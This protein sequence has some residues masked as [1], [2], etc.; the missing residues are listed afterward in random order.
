MNISNTRTVPLLTLFLLLVSFLLY[1][2]SITLP[3]SFI[4]AW[5][6]SE[7]YAIALQFL[8]NGFDIFHPATFNLQTVDGITRMDLPLNEFIVAILMKLLGTTSPV[9]F[10]LYTICIGILGIIFLYLLT[11]RITGSETKSWLAAAFVFFSPIFSFYQAGF[12]PCVPA[13]SFV[14]IAYYFLYRY[15]TSPQ[16]K[17]FYFCLLFLLLAA[18]IRLPFLIFLLGFFIQQAFLFLRRRNVILFELYSF[19][20]AFTIFI[21]YY[22]YNVHLGRVYGNMFLNKFLPASNFSM[23]KE[24]IGRMYNHW[25]LQYFTLWHYLLLTVALV[26]ALVNYYRRKQVVNKSIW[27]NL[28]I[29]GCGEA[30]YFLLMSSQY[31][32]HDYYFLD[33]FFVPVVLLF[34]LCLN[35]LPEKKNSLFFFSLT[36]V[37]IMFMFSDS[38]KEQK[39]RYTAEPWD[40]VE[41]TRQNYAGAEKF[42][43]SI[44]IP[45]EAKILV[46]EAYSTN[47]PLYMMNRKGYTVYQTNRDNAEYA[48]FHTKWDYVVI[49]DVFLFSDV[50]RYYPIVA[51]VLE[52]VAGNGKITIYKQSKQVN[53]MSV[54]NFLSKNRQEII[55]QNKITFEEEKVDGHFGG[56]NKIAYCSELLSNAAILNSE[57]EF[58]VGFHATPNDFK[59]RS[60]IKIG[61]S[62]TIFQTKPSDIQAVVSVSNNG[63]TVY[64]QSYKIGDYYK[65]GKG[66]QK[67]AFEFMVPQFKN[68]NDMLSI[69][70]W[71][72]SHSFLYYDDMEVV[73]Y[74]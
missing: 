30:L 71:N 3:P 34:V 11:K 27:F 50:L 2:S 46:I 42:L 15:K 65:H 28:L 53:A 35:S 26:A 59:T 60:D 70:L 47:I 68:V 29:V 73:I 24:I 19:T 36:A 44:G 13:I 20:T 55:Y 16:R 38:L 74:K 1:K 62:W 17:Y 12:I 54:S 52:P 4:H 45:A 32:D 72:P 9:I 33:S 43:D 7:R 18:L 22:L 10:R 31:F 49:Q 48:L 61:A 6:Q 66:K 56:V 57:T 63:N 40:R 37:F 8:N 51:S 14:L 64:Y 39:K 21:L 23:F 69:Y 5:T 41:L 67:V 58:G 25:S